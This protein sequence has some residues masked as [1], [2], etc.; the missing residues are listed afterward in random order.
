[1]GLRWDRVFLLSTVVKVPVVL[2]LSGVIG[3][4]VWYV[5]LLVLSFGV[6]GVLGAAQNS[7][8]G[9]LAYSSIGN[10]CWLVIA[11]MVSKWVF[12]FSLV[13][14]GIRL[15]VMVYYLWCVDVRVV[16][17]LAL[18]PRRYGWV[19]GVCALSLAG[20]PPFIGFFSKLLVVSQAVA[21]GQAL[22]LGAVVVALG[23]VRYYMDV[24]VRRFFSCYLGF[25]VDRY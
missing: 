9:V 15:G 3:D 16:S 2:I 24:V 22:Y 11:A 5:L 8:R 18:V 10:R 20:V 4:V 23:H 13:V 21:R 7:I 17:Q 12:Y 6:C 25:R 19:I 14:Y 1:M